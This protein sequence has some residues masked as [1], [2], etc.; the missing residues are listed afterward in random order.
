LRLA[1]LSGGKSLGPD[2]L[3]QRPHLIFHVGE[4]AAPDGA[5]AAIL[6]EAYAGSRAQDPHFRSAEL[7]PLAAT[8]GPTDLSFPAEKTADEAR[9]VMEAF[10]PWLID[11]KSTVEGPGISHALRFPGETFLFLDDQSFRTRQWK[12]EGPF[13]RMQEDWALTALEKSDGF[14]WLLRA[15]NWFDGSDGGLLAKVRSL[16]MGG[17]LFISGEGQSVEVLKAPKFSS[18]EFRAPGGKPD[19]R[20]RTKGR[21]LGAAE[22]YLLVERRHERGGLAIKVEIRGNGESLGSSSLRVKAPRR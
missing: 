22:G 9:Q 16:R 8:W 14:V 3:A 20:N 19:P 15:G 12:V 11:T 6:W 5:D 7:V 10:F 1:L 4:Q 13:G 17:P 2:V 18:F 21:I